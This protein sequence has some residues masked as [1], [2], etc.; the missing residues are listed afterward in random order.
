MNATV[1]DDSQLRSLLSAAERAEMQGQV[2]EATRLI[3]AARALAPAHPA[4]LGA[5][6]TLA[7]RKGDAAEAKALLERSLAADP[8]NAGLFVNLASSL[9][10]LNDADGEMKALDKAL[11][12]DPFFFQAL[13]QK[14]A[15]LERLGNGKQAARTYQRALNAIPPGAQL[16]RSWQPHVEHAQKTVSAN[17]KKLDDWLSEK[18][19]EVRSRYGSD[20]QERV[21][22]CL[23]AVVGKNRI[24]VSQPTFSHFPRLPA[25]QFFDRKDFPW[26]PEM[27]AATD[28]I[29]AE[30]LG[31]LQHQRGNFV[32]YLQHGSDEP[33]NQWRELNRSLR[34]S[35]L[36]LYKDGQPQHD[37]IA[38]CPQTVAALAKADVV[39]IPGRGPTS[40]FSLL[41]PKTHIPAHTGTTNIRLTVHIPLI[42][43][44]N[45]RFR[46][47]TQTREWK[48]GT[49]FLFDD[50]IEHEAW[51]DSDQERVILI[52]DVWNP[53]LSQAERDLMTVATAAIGAYYSD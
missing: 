2:E 53:L 18:M 25:I 30:L 32:P 24:F 20:D 6:G 50:T 21:N 4:V 26:V 16:P 45:C 46:V 14:G 19:G 9:R 43:P 34:W 47:G 7:L 40:F 27:E 29:R 44:P 8:T 41:E 36:F 17:L 48:V 22:D 39:K 11:S 12:L 37:N 42:V 3:S 49:T 52:F 15:L 10:G 38:R 1:A 31:M 35:A 23:G 33:L 5:A 28:D 13:I 51:N